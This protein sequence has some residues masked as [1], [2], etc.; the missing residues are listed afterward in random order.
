MRL[1][2]SNASAG[3]E[4]SGKLCFVRMWRFATKKAVSHSAFCGR[5]VKKQGGESG[6]S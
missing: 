2:S 4:Q 6:E 1:N 5:V 3:G